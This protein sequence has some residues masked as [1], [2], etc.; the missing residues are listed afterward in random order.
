MRYVDTSV[1]LAYLTP[2][3]GSLA[4]ETFM[5]SSGEPLAISSWTEVELLSA[6]GVKIRTRQLSKV[7]AHD[8]VDTYSRIVSPHLHRID[9]D[10]ADHRQAVI[11]L[12]GWRTTLRASDGLHLAIAAA[13]EATVFTFDRGM[14]SAG[15]MLGIPVQLLA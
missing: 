5:V 11:L 9:V 2:E 7:S 3:A 15:A 4:A 12:E 14:A 8:V 6:L 13:H 10:D 1:L